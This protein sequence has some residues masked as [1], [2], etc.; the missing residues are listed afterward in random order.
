MPLV[1]PCTPYPP[2]AECWPLLDAL[3]ARSSGCS[4]TTEHTLRTLRYG[5]KGAGARCANL[6]PTLLE[7]LPAR[8]QATRHSAFL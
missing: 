3:L 2:V 5:L 7:V 1:A 8:F 4:K 6:L